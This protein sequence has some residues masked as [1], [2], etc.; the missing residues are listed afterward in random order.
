M[1][2]TNK[3]VNEKLHTTW[4]VGHDG[5]SPTLVIAYVHLSSSW[6]RPSCS[7][8]IETHSHKLNWDGF[9]PL[10]S[11]CKGRSELVSTRQGGKTTLVH[12]NKVCEVV[13]FESCHITPSTFRTEP[14][15]DPYTVRKRPVA[16]V[17][18]TRH[19][20]LFPCPS[21][22]SSPKLVNLLLSVLE[23]F[24]RSTYGLT[25][26][27]IAFLTRKRTL[28]STEAFSSLASFMLGYQEPTS[29]EGSQSIEVSSGPFW[30]MCIC[31]NTPKYSLFNMQK[32]VENDQRVLELL[33]IICWR[34]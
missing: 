17:P 23:L 14:I 29:E 8:R 26:L 13:S 28:K 27:N 3:Y 24:A 10:L 5:P 32:N 7:T 4:G 25:H 9:P 31:T 19:G 30:E 33:H 21:P 34:Y 16:S 15:T 18:V 1:A 6:C 11:L 20:L 12:W 22:V 2:H